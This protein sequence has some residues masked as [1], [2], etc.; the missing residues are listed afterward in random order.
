[1]VATPARI[2]FVTQ[3]FRSALPTPDSAVKT[4]YGELARDTA[5]LNDSIVESFFDSVADALVLATERLNL[6]K[7]DRR[8]FKQDAR[9]IQSFTGGL[10][11][12]QVTPA[13]TVIDDERGASHAAAVVEVQ[14]DL[15]G[16]KTSFISWG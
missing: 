14:V 12:T 16:E 9:G 6:L 5:D 15:T 1:M 13:V 10:D 8:R 2:G 11:F 7:A 4:K 3:Q